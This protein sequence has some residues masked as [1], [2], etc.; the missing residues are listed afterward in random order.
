MAWLTRLANL[1]RRRDLNAEIDEEFAFHID[2]RT[3]ANM[4]AGMTDDEARRDALRR[5][6]SRSGLREETRDANVAAEIEWLGQDLR[7]GV[8]VL[9]RNPGLTTIAVISIAFGTGANVAV[10]SV[11]DALLLRPLPIAQPSGLLAVGSRVLRGTTYQSA[12]SYPD[13][14]DIRERTQTFDGLL[15]YDYETVA[16][17]AHAGEPSR[18][19]FATFVSDNFF[20]V[21]GVGLAIG[22]GFRTDEAA[23]ADPHP[24]VIL[25]DG[26]WRSEF[27]GAPS[28]LGRTLRVAGIECEII[29]VAPPAFTGLHSYIRDSLYLPLG[30]LARVGAVAWTDALDARDVRILRLK[31]RLHPGGTVAQAQAEMTTIERDLERAYPDTNT[32]L[33]L[34]AQTEFD[35][36]FEQRPLD[37]SM[38]VVLTILST[39]VLVVAC[40]NVAGLLGSRAPVRAREMA[41]RLAIGASRAR[42]IRQL[43]TES[44]AIA[45]AGGI[46]GLAVANVGIQLLRQIQFPTDTIA[47]PSFELG[48]RA[49]LFSLTVAMLSALLVGLGPAWQ[50]T[51]VD[52]SAT[53]KATDRGNSSRRGLTGQFAL[54]VLQVALSLVVLTIALFSVQLFSRE[55]KNGPGFRTTRIAKVT[56][57]PGQAGYSDASA[58]RF[59]TRL[60][61]EAR[62]LPGVQSAAVNSAMPLFSFQFVA[63]LSEGRRL[64]RGET[65]V[66]VWSNSVDDGYFATMAIEVIVGRSFAPADDVDV[67]PVAIINDTL[68][69]RYWPDADPIGKRLQILEPD[70]P[71]VQVVGVVSTITYGF[72]GERPQQAIYFPYQ[73]RPSGSMVLL[74]RTAGDSSDHVTPLRDLVRRLDA[75][76]PAYDSQTIEDFYSARVTAIGNVLVRL[77]GGMALMGLMLTMIG[78]YGLVS[79]S[80]SRRVR[81]IGIRIAMG[82]TNAH[83]LRMVLRE[84]MRPAWVGLAMG[85]GLSILTSRMMTDMVPVDYHVSAETYAVVVSMVVIVNAVA[86]FI[87]AGRAATVDPTQALRCE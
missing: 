1:V 21:L 50:T 85:L 69:R 35:Y 64:V 17:T 19:R 12:A 34:L 81:E 57:S 7:H 52:L 14:R 42:L 22:R 37:S 59:Y 87:P 84:G 29:G 45:I 6:G 31:G 76:V 78:L 11:A 75:D 24:V 40:A 70:G 33:T 3:Q 15:A 51:R 86:A 55:L 28:A 71:L 5:F 82:A 79:Y 61:D 60:L 68:A 63:I 58:A 16:V 49:L 77:I 74:A 30:M 66:P 36:R 80:V 10:F 47:P 9:A 4:A 18:V 72:P 13:Y 32:N 23:V 48:E 67:P 46:G 20:D 41:L 56:V 53:I 39:A 38:I 27:G 54:V 26:L 62:A 8:R 25:S 2:A 43:V 83:I 65:V 73:Q 44:L